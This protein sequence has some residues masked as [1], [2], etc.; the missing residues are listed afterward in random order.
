[1]TTGV[2]CAAAPHAHN[3]T[4][5]TLP[6]REALRAHFPS[7]SLTEPRVNTRNR[8]VD[9]IMPLSNRRFSMAA[10]DALIF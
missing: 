8:N 7:A 3:E 2:S 4:C 9:G 6:E 1:M 5:V 10:R